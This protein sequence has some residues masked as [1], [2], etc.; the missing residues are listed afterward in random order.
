MGIDKDIE[1]AY[2]INIV[3]GY[4]KENK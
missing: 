2:T 1:I 4:L 3:N